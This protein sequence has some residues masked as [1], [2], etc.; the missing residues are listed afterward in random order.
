MDDHTVATRN[1]FLDFQGGLRFL[2]YDPRRPDMG[3]EVGV[4]PGNFFGR[5]ALTN[6]GFPYGAFPLANQFAQAFS[7]KVGVNHNWYQGQISFYDDF[8]DDQRHSIPGVE[9]RVTRWGYGALLHR[10][11]FAFVGEIAAGTDLVIADIKR[12]SLA[13]FAELNYHPNRWSN[14]R[15]RF[16][17]LELDRSNAFTGFGVP[18]LS[19]RYAVEGEFVPVPFA[20]IRWTY[21]LIQPSE[22]IDPF[23][24]A[25]IPDER[26]FYVQFHFSY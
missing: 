24:L 10:G 20:E 18:S 23:T 9:R 21:R 1:G 15:A 26:Q 5:M 6:G 17:Y 16:D 11:D 25:E 14:W 22:G 2:P 7:A 8:R 3:V 13:G 19:R 12:N 4:A